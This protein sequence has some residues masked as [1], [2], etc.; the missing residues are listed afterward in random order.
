[1]DCG[2]RRA[3]LRFV[4]D[5]TTTSF[6]TSRVVAH[7]RVK[8]ALVEVAGRLRGER[9]LDFKELCGPG[10]SRLEVVVR[11]LALLELYKAGA[12]ELYQGE[13]FADIRASWADE[14]DLEDVLTDV[15][16]YSLPGGE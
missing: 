3:W 13:R 11:F 2:S 10:R 9:V 7:P 1:M 4:A 14:V 6:A 12:I 16:E 5:F 15:D 8:D